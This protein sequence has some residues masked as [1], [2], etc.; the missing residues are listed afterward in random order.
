MA[1]K[2]RPRIPKPTPGIPPRR[3]WRGGAC[4][5]GAQP[6]VPIRREQRG[7]LG[8]Q[9]RRLHQR[10]RRV[11][12]RSGTLPRQQ[13]ER[14]STLGLTLSFSR[15]SAISFARM[16]SRASGFLL[17]VS[18]PVASIQPLLLVLHCN[19]GAHRRAS[20]IREGWGV[21]ARTMLA[22]HL[23]LQKSSRNGSPA[24]VL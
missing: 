14:V 1:P 7:A 5:W 15:H 20:M 18:T 22:V 9:L 17:S 11:R 6:V 4:L 19:K 23:P 24:P 10:S 2:K 21:N 12:L 3:A 13:V 16:K 8:L